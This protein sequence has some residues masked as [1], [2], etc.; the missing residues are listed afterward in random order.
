M[1]RLLENMR[2]E[3]ELA[4]NGREALDRLVNRRFDLIFMDCHMPVMDGYDT[5]E[6]I[7]RTESVPPPLP[8]V[9]V[10]AS[11]CR[12]DHERCLRVGMNQVLTKPV[13]PEDIAAALDRWCRR[14]DTT[15]P[16]T[17]ESSETRM[18]P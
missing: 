1:R 14:N 13:N 9:A 7:R 3:V 4:S 11:I 15:S 2:C 5:T 17:N 10:T 18:S 8:I 16:G 12:E 6:E